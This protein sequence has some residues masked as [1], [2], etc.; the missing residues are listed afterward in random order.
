MQKRMHACIHLVGRLGRRRV[1]EGE[2]RRCVVPGCGAQARNAQLHR[3]LLG[4]LHG[5]R[6]VGACKV[7]TPLPAAVENARVAR[8]AGRASGTERQ[9]LRVPT[10]TVPDLDGESHRLGG[11]AYHVSNCG[12]KPVGSSGTRLGLQVGTSASTRR[13]SEHGRGACLSRT[14]PMPV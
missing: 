4:E 3:T 6:R 10:R 8:F 11:A 1:A 7:R 9:T 5:N 2:E 13:A 12:G 14:V